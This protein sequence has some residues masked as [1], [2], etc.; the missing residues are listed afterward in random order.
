MAGHPQPLSAARALRSG[1]DAKEGIGTLDLPASDKSPGRRVLGGALALFGTQPLTWAT[2]LLLAA[3]LPHFLGAS[4]LGELALA[5]S[6]AA[7]LGILVSLGIPSYLIRSIALSRADESRKVSGGLV[8]VTVAGLLAALM[9][10]ALAPVLHLPIPPTAFRLALAGMVVSTAQTVVLA[11]IMGRQRMARYAWITAVGSVLATA[12]GI[13]VLARGGGIQGFLLVSF[14][15]SMATFGATWQLADVRFDRQGLG[16][17]LW[18]YLTCAGAPFLGSAVALKV[19]GEVDRVILGL[20]SPAAVVGWYAAAYRIISIPV[21]IPTLIMTP[22]LPTLSR[23]VDDPARFRETL[24]GSIVFVLLLTTPVAALIIALAPAIPPLLHWPADFSNS[25]PLM[26]IL[27]VHEPVVGV[28]MMLAVAMFALSGEHLWLRL[29]IVASVFNP[30]M[31]F[32]L[33]PAAQHAFQNGAI[34]ASGITVA[35]ELLILI[36]ALVILPR[37]MIDRSTAS[38]CLKVLLAGVAMC[39]VA[40]MMRSAW[41]PVPVLVSGAVYFGAIIAARLVTIEQIRLCRQV[42]SETMGNNQVA[43]RIFAKHQPD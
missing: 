20:L 32:L 1:G 40:F 27:A 2:S 23:L 18:W 28:D 36:G 26:M 22:L 37:G 4:G 24:R 43:R 13:A 25:V 30:A 41:L 42:A 19:Y 9:A 29:G 17:K 5:T 11:A 7:L 33:I 8:V 12:A 39:G 16:P 3:L 31:C 21:F 10:V 35:T 34:A 14:V 38:K 15:C 6:V